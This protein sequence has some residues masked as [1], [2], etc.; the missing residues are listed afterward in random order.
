MG[1]L[2][3]TPLF[4]KDVYSYF[5]TE[6]REIGSVIATVTANSNDSLTYR[7]VPGNRPGANS[8]PVFGMD[9]SGMIKIIGGLDRE[10]VEKFELSVRA[11][12]SASPG[13]VAHTTVVIHIQD[14]N[15]NSPKFVT[16]HYIAS[17]AENGAFGEKVVKLE[18]HD[19]DAGPNGEVTYEFAAKDVKSPN[20]FSIDSQTG[21]ITSAASFDREAKAEY[22]F[23][24]I[25]VDRGTPN[26]LSSTAVVTVRI[27]DQND[28]APVFSQ[29]SYSGA[30]NEDALPGTIILSITAIDRDQEPNNV[31]TFHISEGDPLGQFNIRRTGEIYVNKE[32]DR[33][34]KPTYDLVV[35]ATDGTFVSSARVSITILDANDNA[36]VCDQ[37]REVWHLFCL[38]LLCK[39][40]KED[41]MEV[42]LCQLAHDVIAG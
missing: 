16:N 9:D 21:W 15:D 27:I 13:L 2:D 18:A 28:E 29:S 11:E 33:E 31:M 39:N 20:L 22:E 10:S 32:L 41:T 4:E 3:R 26:R 6:N 34:L 24:V 5:V 35:L 19:L 23:D 42:I 12:T 37:V 17:V 38:F 25:A 40:R 1:S 30:V 8:P 7:I 36:P 14:V